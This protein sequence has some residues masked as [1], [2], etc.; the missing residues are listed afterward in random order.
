[1][2][3]TG[4]LRDGT[5]YTGEVKGGG[6]RH[7]EGHVSYNLP[8]LH[9][10][11]MMGYDGPFVKGQKQTDSEHPSGVFRIAGLSTYTGA[12]ADGEITGRGT[13]KWD[14]GREYTGD[15]ELG[16]HHGKGRWTSASGKD[17]YEGEFAHNCR[18]GRGTLRF[19]DKGT[20]AQC[21]YKGGFAA[22]KFHGDGSFL[23]GGDFVLEG[24]FNK[25]VVQQTG[26]ITW[27][28]RATLNGTF[29]DGLPHG[30]G[31]YAAVDG[32][33]EYLGQFA[34]GLPM[35]GYGCKVRVSVDASRVPP[36]EDAGGKGGK[37]KKAP[38][39]KGKGEPEYSAEVTAGGE[40]G[41]V[42][43]VA[44]PFVSATLDE[45]GEEHAAPEVD[46]VALAGQSGPPVPF[47]LRRRM[48]VCLRPQRE[49]DEDGTVTL[50]DAVPLWY[51]RPTL[52]MAATA[53]QRWPSSATRFHGKLES[54][55]ATA[56]GAAMTL[57]GEGA[58]EGTHMG[59]GSLVLPAGGCARLE[60][61]HEEARGSSESMTFLLDFALQ[62]AQVAAAVA[63]AP[64]TEQVVSIPILT[65]R[66]AIEGM[67][68][69]GALSLAL[70]VSRSMLPPPSVPASDGEGGGE[71][72]AAAAAAAAEGDG[73]SQAGPPVVAEWS[74]CA[75]VLS[76]TSMGSRSVVEDTEA[77]VA[78]VD[79]GLVLPSVA[80]GEG[81]SGVDEEGVGGKPS[82]VEDGDG[83]CEADLGSTTTEC[84]RWAEPS[85]FSS[86]GW[87]SIALSIR[88][89]GL[90][91]CVN[92]D[93]RLLSVGTGT[94]GTGAVVAWLPDPPP[95]PLPGPPPRQQVDGQEDGQEG[96]QGAAVGVEAVEAVDKG[97]LVVRVG[98][99]AFSGAVAS[100]CLCT[101]D[102]H[103]D[104]SDVTGC[105]SA[106]LRDQACTGAGA[107]AGQKGCV[108]STSV[109]LLM[110][111]GRG[112]SASLLVPPTTPGGV[113]V[114][115]LTSG[116]DLE[117]MT[118][119][120]NS[121]SE[122]A[123]ANAGASS[124]DSVT[125]I[126][127]ARTVRLVRAVEVVQQLLINVEALEEE[128]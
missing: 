108:E 77:G 7:G 9:P 46:W 96:G 126:D 69:Q 87:H 35:T 44:A 102:D 17:V 22:H 88:R 38:P 53:G 52:D 82:S 59:L 24:A 4:S 100:V 73:Q 20:G 54:A 64:E 105:F 86:S 80:G 29:A 119:D 75:W 19:E 66:R 49:P 26:T 91:L 23:K 95:P 70:Q 74:E 84:A 15:W 118:A 42:A 101:A 3:A 103:V 113:Y 21:T 98:G 107:A 97:A 106:L 117:C 16:E 11:Q 76:L 127:L 36:P 37:G 81:G 30:P 104:V 41:Q 18:H 115:E 62:P 78:A 43:V 124:G 8:G 85:A 67:E 125:P 14:D 33:Y 123:S 99:G 72:E 61:P 110:R 58:A 55:S 27:H 112:R 90:A 93:G 10:G 28:K 60:L 6:I 79:A 89:D 13:R 92:G 50:G 1:M 51:K 32:S 57:E 48:C 122:Q 109:P 83:D 94:D 47:E 56:N 121:V 65:L 12:F 111:G 114:L 63:L 128:A 120:A 39:K 34:R 25:G 31:H 116:V 68:G 2:E 45:E 40:V 5:V 71:G